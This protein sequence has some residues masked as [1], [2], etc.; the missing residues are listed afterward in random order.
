[1]KS[2]NESGK[3]REVSNFPI[4]YFSN[5]T[6][7][8][9][10]KKLKLPVLDFIIVKH[11]ET[12]NLVG[13]ATAVRLSIIGQKSAYYIA[14]LYVDE[15]FRGQGIGTC[16]IANFCEKSLKASS[17]SVQRWNVKKIYL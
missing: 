15:K 16:M 1:M 7:L 3:V 14:S 10:E 11:K 4:R 12:N 9:N 2:G 5:L 8:D 17:L 13:Y 6:L